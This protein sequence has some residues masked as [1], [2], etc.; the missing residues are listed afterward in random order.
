MKKISTKWLQQGLTLIEVMFAAGILGV[1]ILGASSFQQITIRT[2]QNTGDRVFAAQ[3]AVQIFEELRAFVQANQEDALNS[4]QSYNDTTYSPILTSER[5]ISPEDPLSKN[6]VLNRSNNTWKFLRKITVT[7]IPNDTNAKSVTVS[8]FYGSPDEENT[9]RGT[10]PLATTSGILKTNIGKSPP[11]QVYDM[12]VIALESVPAW[13]ADISTIRPI[14]EN[15][16][17][18]MGNRNPG[19]EFRK[20][21]IS[22]MSYGRDPFYMPYVNTAG[23]VGAQSLPWIYFYP[24]K[25]QLDTNT[26]AREYYVE[27]NILGRKRTDNPDSTQAGASLYSP[28]KTNSQRVNSSSVYTPAN[29]NV[30]LH[31]NYAIADSFN[32]A[33]RHQEEVAMQRRLLADIDKQIEATSDEQGKNILLERKRLASEPSLRMLL[34]DMNSNPDRYLNSMIV[35]LHAELVPVPP[36]RNFSDPAKKVGFSEDPDQAANRN[37]YAHKRVVTH[38]ERLRYQGSEKDHIQLRVYPFEVI[39]PGANTLP[40]TVDLS[41]SQTQDTLDTITLFIP[42]DGA[43]RN[44]NDPLESGFLNNP[45]INATNLTINNVTSALS[46]ARIT[47]NPGG[48]NTPNA[49]PY[50]WRNDTATGFMR[51]TDQD[52][53]VT[54][55]SNTRVQ[56]L[57]QISATGTG[58]GSNAGIPYVDIPTSPTTFDGVNVAYTGTDAAALC[59]QICNERFIIGGRNG[60]YA[61]RRIVRVRSVERLTS[62][63]TRWR[64]YLYPGSEGFNQLAS[65]TNNVGYLMTRHRDYHIS[66]NPDVYGETRPGVLLTL[67]NTPTRH[68]ANGSNG[69]LPTARRL[70]GMEYIPAPVGNPAGALGS[71]NSGTATY[72]FNTGRENLTNTS[73]DNAK[74]TARWRIRL[75]ANATPFSTAFNNVAMAV[76]TRIGPRIDQVRMAGTVPPSFTYTANVDATLIQNNLHQNLEEGINGDGDVYQPNSAG[77]NEN[78]TRPRAFPHNVSRTYAYLDMM[79][80]A[81]EQHQFLGDPRLMPYADIKLAH[82]YNWFGYHNKCGA[83]SPN[84]F[85]NDCTANDY[86][87]TNYDRHQGRGWSNVDAD[88]NRLYAL[89]TDG[90][91]NSRSIYNSISGYSSY[92]YGLGGE[93]GTDSSN[94]TFPIRLSPFRT[95]ASTGTLAST[96]NG[97]DQI[98]VFLDGNDKYVR[99]TSNSFRWVANAWLNELFPDA[100]GEF[101][102]ENGNLPTPDYANTHNATA[103]TWPSALDTRFYRVSYDNNNS[104]CQCRQPSTE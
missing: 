65:G 10:K 81:T 80:P 7:D 99:S 31:R 89:Y 53:V 86:G 70:Y 35:N 84:R 37:Y 71:P 4:L 40:T 8:I 3:K 38:P 83:N 24:G 18:E 32:Y 75:N 91:M 27:Q 50:A 34:E 47:G 26:N 22:R 28:Y 57:G 48:G 23:E 68:Q 41:E 6:I 88:L 12:Y 58:T 52:I 15:T 64:I 16:M 19:L 59:N 85:G 30:N 46:L 21:I 93:I 69:G 49:V 20:H 94:T 72:T 97:N 103:I 87:Y 54:G 77:G 90:V 78:L 55:G 33:V 39:P 13:W 14:F 66:V 17:V 1:V 92:Y 62:G 29:G 11:T 73:T 74:N 56:L 100:A 36:I 82:G 42:T 9:V 61:H 76:E 79:V 2:T 96:S 45:N 102:L 67:F 98:N 25:I 104:I 101:W 44:P 60:E 51:I 95:T 43:G 5:I 63:G